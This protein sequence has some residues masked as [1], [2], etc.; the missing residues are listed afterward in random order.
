MKYRQ[1]PVIRFARGTSRRKR[2]LVRLVNDHIWFKNGEKYLDVMNKA[3]MDMLL[4]GES[5]V[6]VTWADDDV[7]ISGL[8]PAD[9]QL[10]AGN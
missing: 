4:Y 6:K 8:S 5:A 7:K 9:Y 1:I 2:R 3:S 10:W